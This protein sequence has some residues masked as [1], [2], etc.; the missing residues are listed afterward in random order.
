VAT[1]R[2]TTL[3]IVYRKSLPAFQTGELTTGYFLDGLPEFV[4]ASGV[5]I[6]ERGDGSTL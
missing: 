6:I 4:V 1:L 2:F 3:K 5:G